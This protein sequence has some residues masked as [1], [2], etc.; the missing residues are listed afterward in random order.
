MLTTS[1]CA[2][3]NFAVASSTI[4]SLTDAEVVGSDAIAEALELLGKRVLSAARS[5]SPG[6]D[7]AD[8]RDCKWVAMPYALDMDGADVADIPDAT[9]SLAC[10]RM[11][12]IL[13]LVLILVLG[14][15]C[16]RRAR[17]RRPP[18]TTDMTNLARRREF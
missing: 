1:C 13:I 9:H 15:R 17:A 11:V 6:R 18:R 7:P 16:C 2:P 10:M 14:L 12:L 8:R 4:S 3:C 5:R